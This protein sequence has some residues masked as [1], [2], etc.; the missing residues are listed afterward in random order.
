[1][2]HAARQHYIATFYGDFQTFIS[3]ATALAQVLVVGR[4]FKH[5]GVG[6]SLLF[7]PV[8]ALTGYATAAL[9]PLLGLAATVKVLENSTS[10]SLQNTVQQ[11]LFL[12]TSRDAKYKAKAA[13]DTLFVRLGDLGSTAIVFAG[14]LLGL[15]VAHYALVNVLMSIVWVV[16]AMKLRKMARSPALAP[17]KPRAAHGTGVVAS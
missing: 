6:S 17:T 2:P 4:A 11:A 12:P 3:V 15:G 5:L 9:M 1:L 13:I 14:G 10:Y 7:L 8:F 16:V